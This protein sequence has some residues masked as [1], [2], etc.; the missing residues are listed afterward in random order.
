MRS[1]FLTQAWRLAVSLM[2]LAACGFAQSGMTY[3]VAP[4]GND[5]NSGTIGSPWRTIQH[6]ANTVTAGATV[7]VRAG[8]YNEAVTLPNSGSASAGYIVFQIYP[9]ET[10]IVDGTGLSCCS[11][12]T[13]GLFNI[14]NRSYVIMSG[15]EIRNFTTSRSSQTPAGIWVAG[16]GSNIQLL[17]N[18]VHNITTTSE[19]NG[20]AFGI[21]VYGTSA[22]PI[23]SLTISGN[24]VYSN[25]TGNSET[26]N[27]DGNVVGFTISNNLVHDNDNVGID[28][29]G[30]KVSGRAGTTRPATARSA[31]TRSTT[32]HPM[33]TRLMVTNMRPTG[34]T[35][36]AALR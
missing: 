16:A 11:G 28:A 32:L 31:G 22:T 15:F 5:S 2:V 3:Y 20:N 13:S 24:Q 35:A 27:V 4:T 7:D 10:A 29:I 17:N 6:A 19:R 1:N 30:F 12:G 36:T 8:T 9:G 33:G 34:F 26:V 23:S 25:K 14:L 21:A 18:K